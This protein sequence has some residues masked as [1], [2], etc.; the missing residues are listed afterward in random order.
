MVFFK[1]VRIQ[2]SLGCES[3]SALSIVSSSSLRDEH[4]VGPARAEDAPRVA[5]VGEEDVLLG[6]EGAH[7]CRPALVLA[8]RNLGDLAQLLVQLQ[9]AVQDARLHLE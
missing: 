7:R 2:A 3:V 5:A 6:D 9:E 1:Y 4:G 8:V